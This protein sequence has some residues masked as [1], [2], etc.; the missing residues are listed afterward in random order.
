M[1]SGVITFLVILVLAGCG[2]TGRPGGGAN[3]PA[4]EAPP[5]GLSAALSRVRATD[6]S[7]K[8]V[9][10]GDIDATRAL[11]KGD[12]AHFTTLEVVGGGAP[13][14]FSATLPVE[15]GFDPLSFHAA[16]NAGLPGDSAGILWGDYDVGAVNDKFAAHGVE[17]SDE[18]GATT[19]TI[20]QDTRAGGA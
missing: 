15:L 12:P 20:D 6:S 13:G 18:G 16:V 4:T 1:R 5:T 11:A 17:R 9:E 10:Y 2:D 3:Q 8:H 14:L 19:W 7:R